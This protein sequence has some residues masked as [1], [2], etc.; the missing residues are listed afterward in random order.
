MATNTKKL[1][2]IAKVVRSKN[3]GPFELTMDV[4]FGDRESYEVTKRSG[5]LSAAA[6]ADLLRIPEKDVLVA[7]FF[8]QAMAFKATVVRST[9]SGSIRDTD[10]YGCQQAAPL[11]E[12]LIPVA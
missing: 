6:I 3:S 5:L 1:G 10:T 12:I 7:E 4:V 2:E 9:V 8:D 11:Q